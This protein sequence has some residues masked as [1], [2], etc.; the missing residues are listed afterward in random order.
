ME[1]GK[2][3]AGRVDPRPGSLED[4][5]VRHVPDA[6][7]L[8][9]LLTH[10]GPTAED[11]AQEA[12]IRVAARLRHLRSPDA[13][14]AYLRR[15]VTNLCISHHRRQKT[16][17]AYVDTEAA[18]SAGR[19]PETGLPDIETQDELRMALAEL[20]GPSTRRG[21]PPFLRRPERRRSRTRA[22]LL[23]RGRTLIGVPRHG[24]LRSRIGG[25]DR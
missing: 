22:R 21:D 16:A 4:L 18:R 10:D 3:V 17:R 14:A 6:T 20:P 9:F 8:A 23:H 19:Q 15:T 24:A 11:V 13:F 25:D 2:G 1:R 7:R 12:F 5:Y